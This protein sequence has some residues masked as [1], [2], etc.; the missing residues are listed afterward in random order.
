MLNNLFEKRAVSFQ[1]IWGAGDDLLDLNQSGTVINSETAF[2]I[3]AVW[4]AVSLISD[5][6]STLPLD[7][8]IRRDGARGPFRPKP[9]WV[10]K[11][12][13][14]Q[15]P[16]A[17]WQS[18][19]VSLLIDGNALIRVFRS[20]GQVVNLV[21]LNPH[22]VQIKRNGIGRVMFEV[23]GEKN[24]L[25]S[26]DVIFIADLVRPGEI[27]GMARVEALKDNFGLSMALESYA[28]RFFSNS[29][30]PQ[31]II[32]FPGNLNSEQAENLRRGFDSAHRGLK[33]SHKT[34]VLS[35]GAEWKPTAVDPENSQLETSR[36]LSVE[37]VARA[38]NIPNHMLGVQGS[39]AYAS[40]E[41]DSIFFVQ[42]TLRPIVQKLE[43]AFSI[44]LNEVPGG[45]NAFLKFNLD[46]LLRG[47]SQARAN[48]YS[49]GLQAGYYT[50]ND[51]RRF[52]DLTPMTDTVA[53]QVRVPLANVSIDDSRVTIE[54]KKVLMVQRLV[55]AGYDPKAVLE[56]LGLP[57]IAHTGVPSVMLQG[58]A[59]IDPNNPE[60]VYEVK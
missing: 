34:G 28:A 60:G 30:T 10:S 42:H 14:D 9:A 51:I 32:T 1:T 45:E 19:I 8:Y 2:K 38:F 57:A 41:Q 52:E 40:V 49:I 47:D 46:G 31:G 33:R 26:E 55:T 17:F 7:A 27:R 25:S 12:D 29:A 22:K 53:D 13:L 20:G 58:V 35:G 54:D 4:S 16:S 37:D 36:R 21:P 6:I 24:L 5:T 48:S 59:Q 15:Q 44:L 18:V 3:T 11:P 56:A 43:T 23:L 50:V 39:T